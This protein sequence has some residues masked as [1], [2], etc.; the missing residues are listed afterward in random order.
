VDATV[1]SDSSVSPTILY[2][3]SD[4]N[5]AKVNEKGYVTGVGE[6]TA[7][8]GAFTSDGVLYDYLDVTVNGNSREDSAIKVNQTN[9]NYHS[10]DT[11]SNVTGSGEQKVLVLPVY[12]PDDSVKATEENRQFIETSFFGSN[13]ECGWRSFKGY[14]EVASYDKLHYSGY[15]ADEW[16]KT[17]YTKQQVLDDQMTSQYIAEAALKDFKKKNPD[18]DFKPYDTND[19]KFIDSLYIIYASDYVI[20][21][22]QT[23]NLWGYRW[24]VYN[25]TLSGYKA[26]AFSWFSLKFL[27]ETSS[28]GGVPKD[29]SNTRII[30]HEHG[31]MLGLPDYYD[32]GYSGIDYVGSFDMQSSNTFDWNAHSKYSVGWVNPY[33]VDEDELKEK[34]EETITLQPSAFNGDC[35]IIPT[36]KWNGT[37]FDEYLILELFNPELGNNEYDYNYSTYSSIGNTGYGVKIYHVD[38]RIFDYKR[39][40]M[41][42]TWSKV[43]DFKKLSDYRFMLNDN[44]ALSYEGH[45]QYAKYYLGGGDYVNYHYLHLLQKG[46][47]STFDKEGDY[48][49]EWNQS[50]LWQSG[51]TFSIGEH[52]GYTNYGTNFF[53]KQDRFNDDSVLNYGITFDEVT[54]D[55]ATLT[56]KYFA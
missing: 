32:Y 9:V 54:P 50:D 53:Y 24:S 44:N 39:D 40:G 31:H 38:A 34:G 49:H 7:R 15:V 28:Y 41:S 5:I 22:G 43:D 48:R 18:F 1:T 45:S 27:K 37:P 14:Y 20:K 46:N 10:I 33:Y 26:S 56:F 13:E 21:D 52:T 11:K 19:D 51:D 2:L 16:Y 12:F 6:G 3:S 30:I 25:P 8:I 36:S 47:V 4:S 42:Y 29:G 55:Y 17:T 23:T 35:L